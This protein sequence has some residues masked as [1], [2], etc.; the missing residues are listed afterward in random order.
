MD[1]GPSQI[2]QICD[3]W[4]IGVNLLPGQ[5][6]TYLY[7]YLLKAPGVLEPKIVWYTAMET[8]QIYSQNRGTGG[9]DRSRSWKQS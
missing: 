5:C 1:F 3:S 2:S 7:G 9:I 8:I 6:V 4:I